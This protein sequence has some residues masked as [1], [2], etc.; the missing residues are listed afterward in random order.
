MR[1]RRG[2][3][4]GRRR[5]KRRKKRSIKHSTYVSVMAIPMD[6][7]EC[8]FPD[9]TADASHKTTKVASWASG[10]RTRRA[11]R[12]NG[13]RS[14]VPTAPASESASSSPTDAVRRWKVV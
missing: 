10:P 14:R 1:R 9:V 3:R 5:N 8:A 12:R 7:T 2:R 6:A 11:A 13:T 4:K